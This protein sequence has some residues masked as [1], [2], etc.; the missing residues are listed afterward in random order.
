MSVQSNKSQ[1]PSMEEVLASIRRIISE[2]MENP[3]RS[4]ASQ[5]DGQHF[6]FPWSKS[7]AVTSAPVAQPKLPQAVSVELT[8]TSSQPHPFMPVAAAVAP[9]AVEENAPQVQ[10]SLSNA[11]FLSAY[12]AEIAEKNS[13]RGVAEPVAGPDVE[14]VMAPSV[15]PEVTVQDAIAPQD[16]M[17][18]ATVQEAVA[19]EA[20]VQTAPEPVH[21]VQDYPFA[22]II[23]LQPLETSTT[24]QMVAVPVAQEAAA[25]APVQDTV[26]ALT[27]EQ[28]P[29]VQQPVAEAIAPVAIVQPARPSPI[30][31]ADAMMAAFI[32]ANLLPAAAPV[33]QERHAPSV[34]QP[35]AV[36]VDASVTTP[37]V[38]TANP[39]VVVENVQAKAANQIETAIVAAAQVETAKVA[40]AHVEAAS[41]ETLAAHPAEAETPDVR[42]S[43]LMS[44]RTANVFAASLSSLT[45]SVKA[46]NTNGAYPRL[47][48]FVAELMKPLV[49]DWMDQ[50]LER[51]VEEAVRDEIK[52]VSKLARS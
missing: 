44:D 17:L 48:E 5:S 49:S 19:P 51:I 37:V 43:G 35:V 13:I 21:P 9:V 52:R 34:E 3:S 39:Q 45:Q 2:E 38:A 28:Q 25:V 15:E 6:E 11:D 36:A 26:V 32:Q 46:G 42:L 12:F 4:T 7:S 23:P 40:P 14:A 31:V 8:E 29:A 47:D 30:H 33:V 41:T 50:H 18:A 24:I 1:E 27:P 22:G 16:T 10:H 20:V